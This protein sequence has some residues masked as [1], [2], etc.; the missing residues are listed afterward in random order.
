[1]SVNITDQVKTSFKR[2]LNDIDE[3]SSEFD[4]RGRIITHLVRDVLGYSGK[5]YQD[6]KIRTDLTIFDENGFRIVII[7]TKRLTIKNLNTKDLKDYAFK[8]A[9]ETTKY[10]GLTNGQQFKLWEITGKNKEILRVNLNF[11]DVLNFKSLFPAKIKKELLFFENLKKEVLWDKSK[12]ADFRSYYGQIQI[13]PDDEKRF[14][15]LISKLDYIINQILMEYFLNAFEI[16]KDKYKEY[17]VKKQNIEANIKATTDKTRKTQYQRDKR[18]LEI[19][20]KQY[21]S[22]I[23]YELWKIFSNREE[24][25]EEVNNDIFCKETIYVMLNKLLFIR[26]CEDKSILP[27]N[28]SNGGIDN[29]KASL[30]N[31]E[32]SYKEIINI[33]FQNASKLYTHFYELGILDWYIEGDSELNTV[34]NRVLWILN[35]FNFNKIDKDILG[36][37]YQKYLPIEE[38]KRL[39]EFYTPDVIIDYILDSIGYK[40]SEQIE[41]KNLFDPACG[42]GG[43]LIRAI[44]RLI[45]RYESKGL[46]SEEILNN[47]VSHIYGFDINPFACHITEMNLLFQII[48]LYTQVK[49]NNKNYK[50]PRFNIYR[51]DTLQFPKKFKDISDYLSNGKSLKF[52][53]ESNEIKTLKNKKYDYVVMNPPYVHQKGEPENPKISKEY[54]KY[55]RENFTSVFVKGTKT[56]GGIKINLFVP[57]V[58]FGIEH[59]KSKRIFGFIVHKNILKVESYKLVRKYILDHCKILQIVDLG[60]GVFEDVTGEVAIMVLQEEPNKQNRDKNQIIILSNFENR[61]ESNFRKF[62]THKILQDKFN[63]TL[64]NMFTIYTDVEF[65]KLRNTIE[66][67]SKDLIECVDITSFGFNVKNPSKDEGTEKKSKFWV[68]SVR[69]KD[70]GRYFLKRYNRYA[71]YKERT[72]RSGDVNV[73]KAKEKLI[74]QRVGGQLIV[75]YD[76]KQLYCFNSVN[77]LTPKET[78][79]DL[80]YIL[81]I[82]NSE[83]MN[84]YYIKRFSGHANYTN[85][86]TQGYL[87]QLPIY[88]PTKQEHADIVKVVTIIL[89]LYEQKHDFECKL[90]DFELFL[91]GIKITK[92]SESTH[93]KKFVIKDNKLKQIKKLKNIILLNINDT[94]ECTNIKVTTYV[95]NWIN[96]YEKEFKKSRNLKNE[97][98]QIKIPEEIKNIE[99]INQEYDN[100]K[101]EL[102]KLPA[103]IKRVETQINEKI[104]RLYK[105]NKID[106]NKIKNFK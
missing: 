98:M 93:V 57:F 47:A 28:I 52:I 31:P 97:I 73:F 24:S 87:E 60:Y 44:N 91:N 67:K 96:C 85:N 82:L 94:I 88:I 75:T 39:G 27:S 17:L 25:D 34:I 51:A 32:E 100:I 63:N 104:Y 64:D 10:V 41:G 101:N 76:D 65:E 105:I 78:N 102:E 66:K 103:K 71:N 77:M 29:L 46:S 59:I 11:K 70:I 42:S 90:D 2:I 79:Y 36:R 37:L 56:R 89:E 92:L 106:I 58:Q 18:Q 3:T 33:A 53:D 38:R 8:Y 69:G 83:L 19:H 80:K 6:E 9:D 40:D 7:E 81:A 12:Y 50:M 1:M 55:L 72:K 21:L 49:K 84:Y 62:R 30:L 23:G 61:E 68:N 95:N 26:I 15:Q 54:R 20:Y 43:F 74:M 16:F 13:V 48:D 5:E 86:V 22:F 45:K 35:R 4:I 14:N 99:N